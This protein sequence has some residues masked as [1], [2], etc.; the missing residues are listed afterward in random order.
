MRTLV[1]IPIYNELRYVSRVLAQVLRITDHVLV[2]DDGSTD[3]TAD[4]LKNTPG[5]SLIRHDH[6]LGY[7]RSL[8]DAFAHAVDHGF[9][10]IVTM[11]CDDQHEPARIPAFIERA[12]QGDVDIVSGSRYL[13]AD[14]DESVAPADRRAIN[15]R[16]T[17]LINRTLGLSLTDAFCGF[18]AHRVSA[19]DRLAPSVEGY[20]FP[21]QFWVQAVRAGLRICELPVRLIYHDP[22]RQFGGR[23]DDSAVRL[24]HYLDVFD[25]ELAACPA[26]DATQPSPLSPA[27]ARLATCRK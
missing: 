19:L 6:N 2:V 16:I 9:D 3:G 25:A 11:D 1:A 13:M 22:T 8:M 23:L 21:L 18:K 20:A 15:R 4:V 27:P 26:P 17:G 24:Q 7:G 12:E 14:G 10:W 5:I